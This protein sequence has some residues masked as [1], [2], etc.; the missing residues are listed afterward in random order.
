MRISD[1]SSDVCSSDLN[2][3]PTPSPARGRR[4]GDPRETIGL[5]L[6]AAI[7]VMTIKTARTTVCFLVSLGNRPNERG[8]WHEGIASDR[9]RRRPGARA[10]AVSVAAALYRTGAR[11]IARLG[12]MARA[13]GHECRR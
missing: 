10:R 7:L 2:A 5:R 6:G 4:T 3:S 9:P 1:W 11:G 12:T 8:V 13:G